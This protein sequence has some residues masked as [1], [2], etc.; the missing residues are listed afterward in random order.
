MIL[1][2]CYVGN[3]NCWNYCCGV[4][5][6]GIISVPNFMKIRQS[7]LEIFLS[8]ERPSIDGSTSYP[9]EGCD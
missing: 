9:V 1:K 6:N 4:C 3:M 7:I 5:S 2:I 8:F